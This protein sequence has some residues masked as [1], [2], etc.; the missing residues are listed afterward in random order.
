[1][2]TQGQIMSDKNKQDQ[3]AYCV[4]MEVQNVFDA[5][6]HLYKR[7]CPSVRSSVR[8]SQTNWIPEK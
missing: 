3:L 5:F 1:M 6:S 7:V 2:L 4:E 8:P